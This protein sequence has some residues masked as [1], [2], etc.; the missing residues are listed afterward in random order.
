MKKWWDKLN[1]MGPKYGYFP[2]AT[3]TILIVKK[4]H[5]E[6]AKRVFQNTQICITTE[7]E[8]HMG[9]VIGSNEFKVQYIENKVAKW[10]QDVET[11]A[12]IGL[13]E[14]QLAYSSFTKAVSHRWTYVQ[15]TVP[16]ISCLFEPLEHVIRESFIPAIVGRKVNDIERK[17]FELPVK[18]GGLGLYNPTK[19][20]D[21]EFNASTRITANLT[22]MICRQE[23]DLTNYD[24]EEV[25]HVIQAIKSEKLENQQAALE[26]V[27]NLVN[28][29][30]KRIL[31]LSQEKGAGS[32][33]T[34]SPVKS[35]GFGLNK[36]EF[37]DA[38]CLRYGW[39][40]PHTPSHCQCGSK[41]DTDHA[42]SC[43]KGGYII[44]RHNRIRDLEAELMREVCTDV[45]VEPP[46]LP[47]ANDNL[48]AGNQAENA[49]LDVS[50][51]GIWGPMQKTFLDVRVMHP[52]SPSYVNKDIAQVFKAH[53]Q[54]KKRTYNERI[55]QVEKGSFTPI[56][57][58]TFGGMGGE[59][60][61]YH[62]RLAQLISEKRNE[63]YSHVVN[64]IR[65]RLRFCLLKSVL[66]SVRGVRGKSK[67]ENITPISNLSFNLI[68]FDD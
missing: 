56:V 18:L 23:K 40:V 11:L 34:T 15:R 39:R 24:S 7:G 41:N 10:V 46:L 4:E 33:L 5:E 20:A 45:R 29:R 52:N 1:V 67:N 36:Q 13:D 66:T 17:V 42:L 9:A 59:A 50:G 58:S 51:I 25:K 19:T 48:V 61:S 64:Y 65:T 31:K 57:V 14:P 27:N 6:K 62:K 43:K 54:E 55:I 53:E 30:M 21:N 2:L 28:D 32:W 3:K 44:M 49:R 12:K 22:E 38:I 47:L 16:N 35:L 68:Q 8:R 26:E 37:K 60:E 63:A